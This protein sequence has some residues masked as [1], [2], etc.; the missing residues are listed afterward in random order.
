MPYAP[1]VSNRIRRKRRQSLSRKSI[2]PTGDVLQKFE[3]PVE[4]L[5]K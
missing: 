1:N 5:L 3:L 4:T 2:Q